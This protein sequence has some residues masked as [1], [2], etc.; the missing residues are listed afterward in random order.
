VGIEYQQ[1]AT[2]VYIL[3]HGVYSM[4]KRKTNKRKSKKRKKSSTPK[5]TRLDVLK[6][7]LNNLALRNSESW[8]TIM[9]NSGIDKERLVVFIKNNG[10]EGLKK[11]PNIRIAQPILDQ[12]IKNFR[13]YDKMENLIHRMEAAQNRL[14]S[15]QL[16]DETLKLEAQVAEL[17]KEESFY[18]TQPDEKGF[19]ELKQKWYAEMEF[20]EQRLAEAEILVAENPESEKAIAALEE[21]KRE[22]SMLK[23]K[24]NWKRMK[25]I[26][27]NIA[28]WSQ[29]ISKGIN[30]VQDSISEVTQ[31]F[32]EMGEM[33]GYDTK[34]KDTTDYEKMFSPESVFDT[35]SSKKK[36]E[37]DFFGGF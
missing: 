2:T 7:Q 10:Y 20:W 14:F 6:E 1:S 22:I 9:A 11:L 28:K 36:K 16:E 31:P 35:K 27:P 24:K 13:I 30:T 23:K 5:R 4:V 29:K 34:K 21:A 15:K 3:V 26:Q 18:T 17:E 33:S 12:M 32:R 8:N 19:V 25:N 37:V